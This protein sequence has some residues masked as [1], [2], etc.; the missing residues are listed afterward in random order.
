MWV[1]RL[2]SFRF[3]N[4]IA[5]FPLFRR[6]SRVG[7]SLGFVGETRYSVSLVAPVN[8]VWQ[9]FESVS[10]QLKSSS[11]YFRIRCFIEKKKN[12]RVFRTVFLLFAKISSYDNCKINEIR[13]LSGSTE[14]GGMNLLKSRQNYFY[15]V[16][17]IIFI[18]I[19]RIQ[20][21]IFIFQ[22]TPHFVFS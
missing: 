9:M 7:V 17:K 3:A 15:I 20:K 21:D 12:F 14:G 2:E 10:I 5:N 4:R 13:N 11:R 1:I 18:R 16:L 19:S 22:L 8:K 6:F